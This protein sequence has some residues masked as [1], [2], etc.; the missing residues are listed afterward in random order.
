MHGCCLDVRLSPTARANRFFFSSRWTL[1]LEE[2]RS[3]R[4]DSGRSIFLREERGEPKMNRLSPPMH[5]SAATGKRR[6]RGPTGRGGGRA[7]GRTRATGTTGGPLLH[8]LQRAV[9]AGHGRPPARGEPAGH[10]RPCVE[11]PRL[12][13][14]L[15]PGLE[16]PPLAVEEVPT[17]ER[18]E[19][20]GWRGL[21]HL[22]RRAAPSPPVAGLHLPRQP[23]HLLQRWTSISS[24]GGPP[25]PRP[26]TAAGLHLLWGGG[27]AQ[28]WVGARFVGGA[29]RDGGS[30]G[31]GGRRA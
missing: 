18:R 31:G 8:L 22:R 17:G 20:R 1:C 7:R 14:H 30:N 19:G 9:G 4:R 28:A 11:L 3:N 25:S 5:F 10:L 24:G 15:R 23:L 12:A 16:L 26:A 6:G 21:H 27:E 2:R 13:D 29:R